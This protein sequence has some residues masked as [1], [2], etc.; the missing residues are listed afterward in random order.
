VTDDD[1]PERHCR[2][3]RIRIAL[4]HYYR[5]VIPQSRKSFPSQV[6]GFQTD[7]RETAGMV[8]AWLDDAN[9]MKIS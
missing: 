8:R 5:I 2:A 3:D 7:A 9:S 4:P 1:H 6:N